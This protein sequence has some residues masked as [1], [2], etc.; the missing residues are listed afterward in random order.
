M[1]HV[2]EVLYFCAGRILHVLYVKTATLK[3]CLK[4]LSRSMRYAEYH[5]LQ[6]HVG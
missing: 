4:K 2:G 3:L 1:K 6:I 5:P